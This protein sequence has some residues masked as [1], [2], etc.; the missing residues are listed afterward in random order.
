[1]RVTVLGGT[2][3]LG[4]MLCRALAYRHDVTCVAR[5]AAPAGYYTRCCDLTVWSDVEEL[6]RTLASDVI[7]HA[8]GLKDIGLCEQSPPEAYETNC[9]SVSYLA[10]AFGQRARILYLSTDYVFDGKRGRYG[11]DD[12][13]IPETVYGQSKLCGE[14]VLTNT[15]LLKSGYAA[16]VRA[17]AVYALEA[18]FPRYLYERLSRSQPVECFGDIYYSPT[19]Y[20]D[21]V[22]MV[23]RLIE[24]P[25]LPDSIFHSCGERLSRY[26]F[27]QAFC[28]AFGF[29]NTLVKPAIGANN[30]VFLYPDLSLSDNRTRSLLGIS[31]TMLAD[32]LLA[33]KH[34]QRGT[35]FASA[36]TL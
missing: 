7:I 36:K 3:Y 12:E 10:R 35:R 33:L 21:F 14:Q 31:R 15:G 24:I 28:K 22:A 27:A 19:Y 1:M 25:R 5:R 11:E 18:T 34:E 16:I 20:R 23:E 2:G 8:A 13:A 32:A 9:E 30:K 29:D 17:S 26:D 6:S 4:G